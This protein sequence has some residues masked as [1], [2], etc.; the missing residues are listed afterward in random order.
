MVDKYVYIYIQSNIQYDENEYIY[1]Y[2]Y[3]NTLLCSSHVPLRHGRSAV[4]R[5][6]E[7]Y[8]VGVEDRLVAVRVA[9]AAPWQCSR[10]TEI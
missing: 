7:L 6:V 8:A 1:I 9:G 5:A 2:T 4:P 3:N 10:E